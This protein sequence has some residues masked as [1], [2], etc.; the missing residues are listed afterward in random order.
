MRIFKTCNEG[1]TVLNKLAQKKGVFD[2]K[3]CINFKQ[4]TNDQKQQHD[5]VVKHGFLELN[6]L[7]EA[8]INP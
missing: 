8:N 1:W 3:M 6:S 2:R 4:I 5:E 7:E